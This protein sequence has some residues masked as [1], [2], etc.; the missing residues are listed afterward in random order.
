VHPKQR[1]QNGAKIP[2]LL[3]GDVEGDGG[4]FRSHMQ[5]IL[6]TRTLFFYFINGGTKV[7]PLVA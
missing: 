2:L 1:K 7:S 4:E 6:E 3:H 5:P